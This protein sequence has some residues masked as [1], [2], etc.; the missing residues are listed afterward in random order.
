MVDKDCL[1][2]L[3]KDYKEIQEKY[4]L[5]E[6][7]KLNEDFQIEKISEVETEFLIREIR[8]FMA[9]KF[10]NYMRFIEMVLHPVSAPMFIFSVIKSM[11]SDEK[12]KLTDVYKKLAK[13]EIDLIELDIKFVEEK[14]VSF[15]KGSYETWQEIKEDMLDIF[16]KIK[17]NWDSKF[18]V[19]NKGYFG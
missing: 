11:G 14:E 15:V 18:E 5:P 4:N 19:N 8:K 13:I 1:E 16:S 17:S 12:K 7:E 2:D 3:K 10:S 6:F 9:E